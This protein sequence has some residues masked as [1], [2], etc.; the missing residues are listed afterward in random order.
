MSIPQ[1]IHLKRN[2]ISLG[3]ALALTMDPE[4][5]L[6]EIE[7]VDVCITVLVTSPRLVVVIV[8]VAVEF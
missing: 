8:V 6:V 2:G 5:V 3:A 4:F 7:P 1:S